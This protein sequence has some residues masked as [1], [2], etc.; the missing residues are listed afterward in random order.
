MR[1][2][3]SFAES[4]VNV[5][6]G[7]ADVRRHTDNSTEHSVEFMRFN[8]LRNPRKAAITPS[9]LPYTLNREHERRRVGREDGYLGS[10]KGPT[11][12]PR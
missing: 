5:R 3:F 9:P 6:D 12:R 7:E 1:K 2:S 10:D 8:P 11:H 4:F